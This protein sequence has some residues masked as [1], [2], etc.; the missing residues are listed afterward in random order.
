MGKDIM[1]SCKLRGASSTAIGYDRD[2]METLFET[3]SQRS[4]TSQQRSSPEIV[5]D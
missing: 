4:L 2:V 5:G 3:T 1:G